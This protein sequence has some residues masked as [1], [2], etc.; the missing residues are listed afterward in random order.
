MVDM[1]LVASIKSA[2]PIPSNVHAIHKKLG[3]ALATKGFYLAGSSYADQYAKPNNSDS[4]T[5]FVYNRGI[6]ADGTPNGKSNYN[7]CVLCDRGVLR[8]FMSDPDESEAAKH[9]GC[10]KYFYNFTYKVGAGDEFV[11]KVMQ[12]TDMLSAKK[13]ESSYRIFIHNHLKEM[14]GVVLNSGNKDMKDDGLSS[15]Q[16]LLL[17][18]ILHNG[19]YC[20]VTLHNNFLRKAWEK[21]AAEALKYGIQIIPGFEATM[22]TY[23][24]PGW[25]A[26]TDLKNRRNLNGPHIV[27][28]FPN[29]GEAEQFWK[30][31]F[32][33]KRPA[34]YAPLASADVELMPMFYTI[35]GRYPNIA[36]VCAHPAC[37]TSLPDV[38]PLSRLA[39]GEIDMNYLDQ[40]MSRVHALEMFNTT[41]K[42]GQSYG[43]SD[44]LGQVRSNGYFDDAEK[45]R[46]GRNIY[47]AFRFF[48]NLVLGRDWKKGEP[49]PPLDLI[50]LN[51]KFA[52]Y[53]SSKYKSFKLVG[54]DSHHFN[55]HYAKAGPLFWFVRDMGSFAQGHN[56]LKLPE[57]PSAKPD[58]AQIVSFLNKRSEIP[59]AEW[60]TVLFAET[61][62]DGRTTITKERL[63]K[64]WTQKIYDFGEKMLA[65]VSRQGPVLYSDFANDQDIMRGS[66]P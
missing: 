56:V 45:N 4:Q 6:N 9:F 24:F 21:L 10:D 29:A 38:D 23:Q 52:E 55:E 59:G 42:Q 12:T 63:D 66:I 26:G 37:D 14:G 27:L 19:D 1:A 48:S 40:M 11:Q 33:T 25:L 32:S 39:K 61:T 15:D 53:C 34:A 46:R 31:Y 17:N 41:V 30:E 60:G 51:M 22:P 8:V 57:V 16:A 65:Y 62:E 2:L 13:A 35:G 3:V 64:S 5:L 47:A 58:A 44:Y 54:T 20:S 50:R 36:I 18:I 28:L 7:V 43:L 49:A